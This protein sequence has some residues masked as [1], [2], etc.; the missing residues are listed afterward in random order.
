[1][2]SAAVLS[3][4]VSLGAALAALFVGNLIFPPEAGQGMWDALPFT[5]IGAFLLLRPIHGLLAHRIAG[6]TRRYV[7]LVLIGFVAGGIV[8]GGTLALAGVSQVKVMRLA[9]IGT[10]YGGITAI[11]WVVFHWFLLGRSQARD[12]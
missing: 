7:I 3:L 2:R 11:F 1:M 5:L 8:L 10:G 4:L 9:V 6:T 12:N